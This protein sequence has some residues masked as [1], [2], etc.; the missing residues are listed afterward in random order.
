MKLSNA[1]YINQGRELGT[2]ANSAFTSDALGDSACNSG[3]VAIWDCGGK[4]PAT[5]AEDATVAINVNENVYV[6]NITGRR[7]Y[8]AAVLYGIDELRNDTINE[9]TGE[10][11]HVCNL[12]DVELTMPITQDP[13]T[14]TAVASRI[15]VNTTTGAL[16]KITP[17]GTHIQLDEIKVTEY[18]GTNGIIRFIAL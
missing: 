6:G 8:L 1:A 13:T 16:H 11:I 7:A 17:N 18:D 15:C 10:K 5:G 14:G 4:N 3:V 12:R 9:V 2:D